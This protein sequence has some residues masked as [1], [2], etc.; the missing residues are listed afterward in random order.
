MR[1]LACDEWGFGQENAAFGQGMAWRLAHDGTA[2]S[3]YPSP[4]LQP[5]SG[6]PEFGCKRGR[7]RTERGEGADRVRGNGIA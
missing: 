4:R 2:D 1:C 3:V 5:N 7:E 6:K